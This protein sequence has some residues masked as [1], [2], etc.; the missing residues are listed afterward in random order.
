[1]LLTCTLQEGEKSF[2]QSVSIDSVKSHLMLIKTVRE[3][4]ANKS[5]NTDKAMIKKQNSRDPPSIYDI[6]DRVI[7]K[8]SKSKKS[9]KV[10]GKGVS[11]QPCHEASV[12]GSNP[13]LQKYK[14]QLE[15]DGKIF[16]EWVPVN[17]ISLITRAEENERPKVGK[18][19]ILMHDIII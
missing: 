19:C 8:A 12:I 11:V 6:G 13:T 7:V 2:L 16:E 3:R 5:E 1:M 10:V 17:C 9:N 4:A 14:V 18:Q 15:W